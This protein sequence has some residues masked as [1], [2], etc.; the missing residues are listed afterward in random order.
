MMKLGPRI[1]GIAPNR[2]AI[3]REMTN[4][5]KSPDSVIKAAQ[6]WHAITANRLQNIIEL[7]PT[8]PTSGVRITGPTSNPATADD[9]EYE[10]SMAGL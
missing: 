1:V 8:I 4:A 5:M 7:R 10:S 6:I 2:P 3:N 9:M